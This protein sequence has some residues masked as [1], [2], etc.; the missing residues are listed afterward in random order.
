METTKLN[1]SALWF[2]ESG[3]IQI[4]FG[5]LASKRA[6]IYEIHDVYISTETNP[7]SDH[8]H[9]A[10]PWMDAMILAREIQRKFQ[11]V[12]NGKG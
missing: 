10:I 9:L 2:H 11:G 6:N 1:L 4:R 8:D 12:N 5:W 3:L 7:F